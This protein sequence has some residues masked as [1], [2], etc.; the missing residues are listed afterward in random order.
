MKPHPQGIPI[1]VRSEAIAHD[2][3]IPQ[4]GLVAIR[5]LGGQHARPRILTQGHMLISW[6]RHLNIT[7]NQVNK[8]DPRLTPCQAHQ[9]EV[10]ALALAAGQLLV[11]LTSR[12]SRQARQIHQ[13][14][15][16]V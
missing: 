4:L 7:Q 10:Q 12:Q 16:H 15:K 2:F 8:E 14:G 6:K 5:M 9:L 13:G 3:D 11:I 1:D